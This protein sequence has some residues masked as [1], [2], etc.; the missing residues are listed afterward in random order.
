MLSHFNFGMDIDIY[1]SGLGIIVLSFILIYTTAITASNLLTFSQAPLH[2]ESVF[3]KF[4]QYMYIK[5]DQNETSLV[6]F[7]M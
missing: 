1:P 4:V 7:G 5:R 3:L 2:I 6:K